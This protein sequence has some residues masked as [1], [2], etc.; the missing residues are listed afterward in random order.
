VTDRVLELLLARILR[1]NRG[2]AV[3]AVGVLHVL[4]PE[5]QQPDE[6][7]AGEQR[8]DRAE[9]HAAHSRPRPAGTG[10]LRGLHGGDRERQ[11]DQRDGQRDRDHVDRAL[12][13][14]DQQHRDQA[15]QREDQRGRG[16]LL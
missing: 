11:P 2:R 1:G 6:R 3:Q 16:P 7:E 5:D 15:E 4:R 9:Q 12:Q 14:A 13:V 8:A 10:P